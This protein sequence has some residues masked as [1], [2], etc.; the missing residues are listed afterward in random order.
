MTERAPLRASVTVSATS[1]SANRPSRPYPDAQIGLTE[2]AP[3]RPVADPVTVVPL[4]ILRPRIGHNQGGT[5]VAGA[6]P[7]ILSL[8]ER[9]N[10][11]PGLGMD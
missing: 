2:V 10:D 6:V 9:T 1:E 5:H 11:L 8:P 3:T 7:F 4:R